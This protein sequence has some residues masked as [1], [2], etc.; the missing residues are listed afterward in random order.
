LGIATCF[1]GSENALQNL[2]T[3]TDIRRELNIWQN[4]GNAIADT[5]Y[6]SIMAKL[7]DSE[8]QFS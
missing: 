4:A 3:G 7:P 2:L 8:K 5:V 6:L 1:N